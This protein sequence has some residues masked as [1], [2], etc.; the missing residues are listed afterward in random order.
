MPTNQVRDLKGLFSAEPE[1]LREKVDKAGRNE[2]ASFVEHE[3]IEHIVVFA[4]PVY[5]SIAGAGGAGSKG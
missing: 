1:L 3:Q 4:G 2:P 5:R